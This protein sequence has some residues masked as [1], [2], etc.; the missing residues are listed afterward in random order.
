MALTIALLREY[1]TVGPDGPY[2]FTGRV[3]MR[4]GASGSGT[5]GSLAAIARVRLV[6][7]IY[8]LERPLPPEEMVS[9]AS[10]DPGPR[11]VFWKGMHPP[12]VR[13][14]AQRDDAQGWIFNYDTDFDWGR[15]VQVTAI[16]ED[17]L[18]NEIG[19]ASLPRIAR[20]GNTGGGV[21]LI[22]VNGVTGAAAYA[23]LSRPKS[24]WLNLKVRTHRADRTR[25]PKLP[26]PYTFDDDN[27]GIGKAQLQAFVDH[28]K[29]VGEPTPAG[30]MS[31]SG[32]YDFTNDATGTAEF[33]VQ[34][35][36][37]R[38][39]NGRRKVTLMLLTV[40]PTPINSLLQDKLV[41]GNR[42]PTEAQ[43]WVLEF[44]CVF[45][46]G[47]TPMAIVPSARVLYLT[48]GQSGTV[49]CEVMHTD[50]Y[51]QTVTEADGLR[52]RGE[53][54]FFV[55][56][57]LLR[58][59]RT[60]AT[61]NGTDTITAAATAGLDAY[62]W[63]TAEL[64]QYASDVRPR[65]LP[66]RIKVVVRPAHDC[67]HFGKGVTRFLTAYTP[68]E[69]M[70]V[71]NLFGIGTDQFR[72]PVG[73]A[74]DTPYEDDLVDTLLEAGFNCINGGI[75]V[76]GWNNPGASSLV[77][78]K[79][80][81]DAYMANFF[82]LLLR[83]P[84]LYSLGAGDDIARARAYQKWVSVDV[85]WG[86]DAVSYAFQKCAEN[87][88]IILVDMVDEANG[89]L[90]GDPT[91]AVNFPDG[92]GNPTIPN[93]LV[94][95]IVAAARAG[96]ALGGT[97][98]GISWPIL[99]LSHPYTAAQW[100][101]DPDVADYVS[102]F[103]TI[104]DESHPHYDSPYEQR[105][106]M[107][108]SL[109]DWMVRKELPS[110]CQVSGM[111]EFYAKCSAGDHFDPARDF[112]YH[113]TRIGNDPELSPAQV[114][115]GIVHGNAGVRCYIYDTD[116]TNRTRT[117][118]PVLGE[119]QTGV[120]PTVQPDI[121][122][123]MA[124]GINLAHDLEDLV[125]QPTSNAPMVDPVLVCG[126]KSSAAGELFILINY[127]LFEVSAPIPAAIAGALVGGTL[128]RMIGDRRTTTAVTSSPLNVTI[129]AKEVW[130]YYKRP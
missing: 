95:D 103:W 14:F 115:L 66:A 24:G 76:T 5:P 10:T 94:T 54:K 45:E 129:P 86:M 113:L 1:P 37:A 97:E 39:R 116:G 47:R 83:H 4:V 33:V 99:G 15:D 71:A 109:V 34:I 58:D 108:A 82:A 25:T 123:A 121:W 30:P 96:A 75:F 12:S 18:G 128:V 57:T 102:Y 29:L 98:I 125:L 44:E 80:I 91:P 85:P 56:L 28:E 88:K 127:S 38:Y 79:A 11:G 87:G 26:P 46:N 35:N 101:N 48:P 81:Y 119:C 74:L 67:P 73:G 6:D 93:T 122:A 124:N 61:S 36:T 19:R 23:E 7:T 41:V 43:P 55:G 9:P 70:F 84:D 27:I 60:I 112:P 63:F 120:S 105:R 31:T 21:W 90:G 40:E 114:W 20:L 104:Y 2:V 117:D 68:G 72:N 100:F 107:E 126:R 65:V 89:A 3:S 62:T 69:S 64:Q 111:G 92:D 52:L 13:T 53:G 118:L 106:G 130:V 110:L 59:Q 50:G 8:G 77:A 17:A 51:R 42:K 49:S 16:A 32:G 78:W 22:E